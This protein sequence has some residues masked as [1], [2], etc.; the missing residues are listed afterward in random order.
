MQE[1]VTCVV[2]GRSFQQLT[3]SISQRSYVPWF[4]ECTWIVSGI[5]GSAGM[6]AP[7][8]GIHER[9]QTPFRGN[10]LAPKTRTEFSPVTSLWMVLYI[11]FNVLT[12]IGQKEPCL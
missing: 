6:H 8:G 11:M 10:E 7:I 12:R 1:R 5:Q 9:L 3:S 4:C 2:M